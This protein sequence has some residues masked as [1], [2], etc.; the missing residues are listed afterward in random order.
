M[1]PVPA[2]LGEAMVSTHLFGS[3][4][5]YRTLARSVDV[6]D[7]EDAELAVFGFG[8]TADQDVLEALETAPTAYGRPLAGGRVAITRIFA[9]PADESGRATLELR[10]ILIS[11]SSIGDLLSTGFGGILHQRSLW[12][13]SSFEKGSTLRVVPVRGASERSPAAEEAFAAWSEAVIDPTPMRGGGTSDEPPLLPVS[14]RPM[15]LLEPE[16][17]GST[18]LAAL[19]ASL[20][21]TDLSSLRW[22]VRLL[23]TGVPV[24]VATLSPSGRIASGRSVVRHRMGSSDHGIASEALA[25]TRGSDRLPSLGSVARRA[26]V[27][28]SPAAPGLAALR[29]TVL[30]AAPIVL[31]VLVILIVA[32]G[33]RR[34]D[35][36]EVASASDIEASSLPLRGSRSDSAE[37]AGTKAPDQSTPPPTPTVTTA[38]GPS[39]KAYRDRSTP[40]SRPSTSNPN[41][42]PASTATP[43]RSGDSQDGIDGDLDGESMARDPSNDP[44]AAGVAPDAVSGNSEAEPANDPATDPSSPT[45]DDAVEGVSDAKDAVES[46]ASP[47]PSSAA[48]GSAASSSSATMVEDDAAGDLVDDPKTGL[49]DDDPCVI[50]GADL[51]RLRDQLARARASDALGDRKAFD[52]AM[53]S[54]IT[55]LRSIGLESVEDEHRAEVLKRLRGNQRPDPTRFAEDWRTLR[56][57]L[58]RLEAWHAVLD[59]LDAI[60]ERFPSGTPYRRELAGLRR[61][62]LWVRGSERIEPAMIRVRIGRLKQTL[63]QQLENAVVLQSAEISAWLD[64]EQDVGSQAWSEGRFRPPAALAV[65]ESDS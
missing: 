27:E 64:L 47:I 49:A 9:G 20:T 51:G 7:A 62:A 63:R 31:V 43:S 55:L 5:G 65:V 35:S 2:G 16:P 1:A 29:T 13:R 14:D 17:E 8:Q 53:A 19:A 21:P 24:D 59:E 32:N 60:A 18:A 30:A 28:S 58:C 45:S 22:G 37:R 52:A 61:D 33:W 6:T 26:V 10:T 3:H 54:V 34:D 46:E 44:P 25:E 11:P 38:P 42:N 23:S 50:C 15:V 12:N 39:A 4:E 36:I 41:E 40:S 56:L 57:L 48:A